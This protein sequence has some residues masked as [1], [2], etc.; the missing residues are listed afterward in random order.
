MKAKTIVSLAFMLLAPFF[1]CGEDIGETYRNARVVWESES[2]T[3]FD[4]ALPLTKKMEGVPRL[5]VGGEMTAPQAINVAKPTIEE[6]TATEERPWVLLFDVVINTHGEAELIV[7]LKDG[8]PRMEELSASYL[9][10][11]SWEPATLDGKPVC[12]RYILTNRI[13][14]Q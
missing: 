1:G 12:V 8:Y 14:Y 11:G 7:S 13:H 3:C 10:K 5:M 4:K 2:P 9:A 6:L